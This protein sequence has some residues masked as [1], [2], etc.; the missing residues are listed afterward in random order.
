MSLKSHIWQLIKPFFGNWAHD[1]GSDL[2]SNSPHL[3]DGTSLP[4]SPCMCNPA[5]ATQGC[6]LA[7]SP[8]GAQGKAKYWLVQ[9]IDHDFQF[10]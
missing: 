3:L 7:L 4:L 8:I 6:F 9:K 5:H 10:D 1:F 2:S